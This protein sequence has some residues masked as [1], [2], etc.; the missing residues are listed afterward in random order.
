MDRIPS[1]FIGL[2]DDQHI[3]IFNPRAGAKSVLIFY[4]E[5][6][7]L[8]SFT[9]DGNK[10]LGRG[11]VRSSGT[12]IGSFTTGRGKENGKWRNGVSLSWPKMTG[13]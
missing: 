6:A 10:G 7:T 9:E 12:G 2:Y 11:R 5:D 13:G 1:I 4:F 3:G 8:V